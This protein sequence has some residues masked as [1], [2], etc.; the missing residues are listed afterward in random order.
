MKSQTGTPLSSQPVGDLIRFAVVMAVL[1]IAGMFVQVSLS[2]NEQRY[3]GPL[4]IYSIVIFWGVGAAVSLSRLAD[5]R[6]KNRETL[7]KINGDTFRLG[8]L[9]FTRNQIQNFER[10]VVSGFRLEYDF[11]IASGGEEAVVRRYRVCEAKRENSKAER[12]NNLFRNAIEFELDL[13]RLSEEIAALR[14][15][16]KT[17]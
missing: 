6:A 1:G 9:T 13:K 8:S 11:E 7:Y 2:F 4:G 5:I 14:V 15:R 12:R 10:Y 17:P 3:S 16:Q